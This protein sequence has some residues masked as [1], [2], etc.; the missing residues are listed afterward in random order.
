MQKFL[1]NI[2]HSIKESTQMTQVVQ[3]KSDLILSYPVH[4]RNQRSG[5]RWLLLLSIIFNSC[6]PKMFRDLKSAENIAGSKAT[7]LFR[8]GMKE[9]LVY[10]TIVHFRDKEFSSLTYVNAVNDSVF[11]IVLLTTFGNTLLEAEI[12]REKFIVNNVIS[13]L[14]KRPIL[15]LFESDWRLLLEGNFSNATPLL[16]SESKE[17]A[18]FDYG[19]KRKHHLFYYSTANKSVTGI[20]S[21]K[22]KNKKVIV[23]VD[24]F[25][26]SRPEK[27][28]IDHPSMKLAFNFSLLKKVSN[29]TGE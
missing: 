2:L 29:E 8:S 15:K 27:F 11:K 10:K 20:E 28:S 23:K 5:F 19:N 13:Y 3:D 26:D 9:S 18:V 25:S 1:K 6:T 21:Y 17:Q 24:S 7:E 14:D 12:S 4:L 16:F 22:G